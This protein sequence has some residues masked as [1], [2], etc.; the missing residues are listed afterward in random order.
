MSSGERRRYIDTYLRAAREEPYR[1]EFR[2]LLAIHRD[3][4]F[5]RI[6]ERNQ[7]LTW[8]RMYLLQ[9]ENLLRKIDC[10]V[11]QP[12]WDWSLYGNSPWNAPLWQDDPSWFGTNGNIWN[13]E[14][15][16]G[17]FSCDVYRT[18]DDSCL[19]RRFNSFRILPTA[20][21]I[22]QVLALPA[23]DVEE[24]Y[25]EVE[26]TIHN[27]FHCSVGGTMCSIRSADAPEFL[28][29]HGFV[30]KIWADWQADSD[31]KYDCILEPNRDE[32]LIE[33]SQR[34]SH[35]SISDWYSSHMLNMSSLPLNI[36]ISYE[37]PTHD[38]AQQLQS[39][40]GG[41]S[42]Q[43]LLSLKAVRCQPPLEASFQLFQ[44]SD[45]KRDNITAA[46]KRLCRPSDSVFVPVF[47]DNDSA[48]TGTDF[49]SILGIG[50]GQGVSEEPTN[51]TP[52][53]Q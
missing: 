12:Y 40:L 17:P 9:F 11:T 37:E 44:V 27:Q 52:T 34:L 15:R 13:G 10:R 1:S 19:Y 36:C 22:R 16:N 7:F 26:G 41:L 51:R 5:N 39:A 14:V 4:F 38:L 47:T 35:S 45:Q 30:D 6:H 53:P 43:Q 50:A 24:W 25:L 18:I 28:L 21:A 2:Q 32:V 29:H 3:S 33:L 49:D 48:N 20:V 31:E 23:D 46:N 42:Y 8:H